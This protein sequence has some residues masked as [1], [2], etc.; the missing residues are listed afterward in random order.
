ML[1]KNQVYKGYLKNK[2]KPSLECRENW[3]K[4]LRA[5]ELMGIIVLVEKSFIGI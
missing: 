2:N 3:Q 4:L 5:S 1:C